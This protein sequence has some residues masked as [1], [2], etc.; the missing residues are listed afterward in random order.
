MGICSRILA[1]EDAPETLAQ[2][3][4]V[5]HTALMPGFARISHAFDGLANF[6]PY[7]STHD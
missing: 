2:V 5:S 3:S 7:W 6:T 4:G 1:E